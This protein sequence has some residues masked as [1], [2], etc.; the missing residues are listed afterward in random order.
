M[1]DGLRTLLRRVL[2]A[3]GPRLQ[4]AAMDKATR[5]WLLR[6]KVLE[7]LPGEEALASQVYGIRGLWRLVSSGDSPHPDV[8]PVVVMLSVVFILSL[9]ILTLQSPDLL[10]MVWSYLPLVAHAALTLWFISRMLQWRH[11]FL[12]TSGLALSCGT[13]GGTAVFYGPLTGCLA[14]NPYDH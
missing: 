3:T 12:N 14:G 8:Q 5:G 4:D 6:W 1:I 2:W 10:I 7:P 9:P 13:A 11:A